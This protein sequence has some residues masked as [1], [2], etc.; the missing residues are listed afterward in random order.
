MRVTVEF[1]YCHTPES[2]VAL[3]KAFTHGSKDTLTLDQKLD[4]VSEEAG[5]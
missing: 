5:I 3:Q 4:C 2:K 1:N